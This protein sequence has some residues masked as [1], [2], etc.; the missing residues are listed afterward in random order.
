LIMIA[1]S[2]NK[3]YPIDNP[4][5]HLE[6]TMIHEAM[7]LEYSG[8]YLAML[9]FASYI[10]ITIF[11]LLLSNIIWPSLFLLE[12]VDFISIATI[13][14]LTIAKL[15]ISMALLAFF[16][17]IITKIRLYRMQEYLTGAFLLGL[18]GLVIALIT[19]TL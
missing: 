12:S 8:P 6:L 14:I 16:E 18:A 4:S 7:V 2:E 9:E 13:I 3:R 10:K 5:T 19:N 17:S 11:A 1:L 15:I